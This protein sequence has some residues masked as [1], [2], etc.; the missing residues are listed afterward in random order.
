M[1]TSAELV[2]IRGLPGSGKSTLARAMVTHEHFEADMFFVGE[3]G[4]YNYDRSKIKDAHDWCQAQV[5]L[6]LLDGKRVVVSNTF[7]REFEIEPYLEM[8]EA[9]GIRPSI[10]EATGNY[11]NIHGVPD[12]TIERMRQQMGNVPRRAFAR[13]RG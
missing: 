9:I 1:T 5:Y 13:K 3:N 8:C 11:P 7:I 4:A 10:I 2:L 6:A 12:D